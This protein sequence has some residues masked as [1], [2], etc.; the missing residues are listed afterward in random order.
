MIAGL[1]FAYQLLYLLDA[2]GFYTPGLHVLGVHVSRA[3]GQ[4]LVWSL[5]INF[6]NF[7]VLLFWYN[8]LGDSTQA[9]LGF[10]IISVLACFE[11]QR[12]CYVICYVLLVYSGGHLQWPDEKGLYLLSDLLPYTK[13]LNLS[14]FK[15]SLS[16]RGLL[17]FWRT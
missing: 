7:F 17:L 11:T 16:R 15:T 9:L 6:L 10:A 13:S 4:E 3:T 12:V 1:S 2:T 14:P 5:E 8:V